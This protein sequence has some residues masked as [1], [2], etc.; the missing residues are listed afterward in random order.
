[1]HWEVLK[2][3]KASSTLCFC[4]RMTTPDV[5]AEAFW[6]ST[7]I[8][9]EVAYLVFLESRLGLRYLAKRIGVA[10]SLSIA[11]LR[12]GKSSSSS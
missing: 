11:C 10:L 2:E 6:G 5:R 7:V 4:E 3:D 8:T 9:T 12:Y 1:M